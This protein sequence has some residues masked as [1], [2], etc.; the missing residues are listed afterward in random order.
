MPSQQIVRN[1]ALLRLELRVAVVAACLCLSHPGQFLG[2]ALVLASGLLV[3]FIL[4]LSLSVLED[5]G[6]DEHSAAVAVL[7]AYA[8]AG[9]RETPSP[10]VQSEVFT[11]YFLEVAWCAYC[12]GLTCQAKAPLPKSS[13]LA[14]ALGA[15]FLVILSLFSAVP[16]PASRFAVRSGV[17]AILA[18]VQG[19]Q[20]QEHDCLALPRG[21]LLCFLPVLLADFIV[22]TVF[23]SLGVLASIWADAQPGKPREEWPPAEQPG[24]I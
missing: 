10:T 5:T 12:L 4:C 15:H 8:L 11:R 3:D 19:S 7:L 6:V 21:Y 17:F 16:E 2:V 20:L 9:F 23:A 14:W 18:T 24:I 22:V 13:W 1:A